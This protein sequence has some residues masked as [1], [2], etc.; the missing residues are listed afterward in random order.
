[1]SVFSSKVDIKCHT[2]RT[3]HI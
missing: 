2:C 1:M 3:T